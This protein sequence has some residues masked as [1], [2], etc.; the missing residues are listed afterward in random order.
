[1]CCGSPLTPQESSI[2]LHVATIHLHHS[3]YHSFGAVFHFVCSNNT[4]TSIFTHF[5]RDRLLNSL[6]MELL[7]HGHTHLTVCAKLCSMLDAQINPLAS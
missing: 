2:L 5:S 1:M 6:G 3:F 4:I 7:G